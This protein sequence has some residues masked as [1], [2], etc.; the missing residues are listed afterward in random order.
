MVPD[1]VRKGYAML[2]AYLAKQV[3]VSAS[4]TRSILLRES[5]PVSF[6]HLILVKILFNI[7]V[8]SLVVHFHR[9]PLARLLRLVLAVVGWAV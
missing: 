5:A 6:A 7:L 4:V 8:P 2:Q 9:R 3:E 1:A